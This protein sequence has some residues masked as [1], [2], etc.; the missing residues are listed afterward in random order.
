MNRSQDLRFVWLLLAAATVGF[1]W[2]QSTLS[3]SASLETSDAV[4]EVI[5]PLVGGPTSFLG[6]LVDRFMR[7][8]A[9]FIEFAILG[10]E[11]ELF[12]FGR[13]TSVRTALQ[14]LF[15]LSVGACDELLQLLTDRGA[16]LTDVLIDFSGYLTA[17]GLTWLFTT[18]ILRIYKKRKA[19]AP[20]VS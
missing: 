3:P 13:H 9:H 4:E 12:L 19:G 15:G 8:I 16:S 17:V 11:G 1:I 2:Q 14:L 6:S 10:L 18:L 5:I 7:K 20:A